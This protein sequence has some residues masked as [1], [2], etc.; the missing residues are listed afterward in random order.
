MLRTVLVTGATG[1]QG[2]SVIKALAAL[3]EAKFNILALTRDV[4]SPRSRTL[5][6]R[7]PSVKL[8][9]GDLDDP[10]AI[11]KSIGSKVWGIFSVQ[12]P[13]GKKSS[14][15]SEVAQGKALVSAALRNKAQFFVY[16]SVDR[17]GARSEENTPCIVPHF[18]T[19]RQVEAHLREAAANTDM[20]YT[21]LRP[22]FFMEN[23]TNDF[24]G[25]VAAAAWKS[26]V[27]PKR[28]QLVSTSDIGYFAAQA[29]LNPDKYA[30][31]AISLAGDE[32]TY[33]EAAA[34]WQQQTGSPLPTGW[35]FV[36]SALLLGVKDIR[37]MFKWF[38]DIGY[39]ANIAELKSLHPGL[40]DFTTWVKVNQKQ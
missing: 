1:K 33:K 11:F 34:I 13:Y 18:E 3:P 23:L 19:K 35:G 31:Q 36:T 8:I 5:L 6:Q 40:Q 32:L 21:I 17:G 9:A 14:L 25:K 7:Y 39:G 24:Q 2:G 4:Q 15:E 20:R 37:Y 30:G 12:T 28:L 29:F 27:D 10:D 22:T 26:N 16:S 38:H